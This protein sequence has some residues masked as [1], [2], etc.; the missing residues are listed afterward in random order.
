MAELP[1]DLARLGD[2]LVGAAR[3]TAA[4]RRRTRRFAVATAVGALAFAAL[5][6]AALDPAQRT[7][8][9]ADSAARYE[10]PGCQPPR[11]EQFTMAA[12]ESRSW[13]LKRP[14]AWPNYS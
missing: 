12:C 1:R 10:Q 14:A 4:R 6:P 2:D 11:G 13:I 7:F 3:R 5:T 9:F 8:T